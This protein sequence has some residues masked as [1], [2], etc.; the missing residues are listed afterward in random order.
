MPS[1][2]FETDERVL[3][4][5]LVGEPDVILSFSSIITGWIPLLELLFYESSQ[6]VRNEEGLPMSFQLIWPWSINNFQRCL[7]G[8][9]G[10]DQFD[11][12]VVRSRQRRIY[13]SREGQE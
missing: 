13:E 12:F 10:I 9:Q 6:E 3:A 7:C 8:E 5:E 4:K 11:I 2:L 1:R